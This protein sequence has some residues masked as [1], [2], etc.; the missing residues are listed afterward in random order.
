MFRR[1]LTWFWILL[2][3]LAC[4]LIARLVDIQALHAEEYRD[5]AAR[6]LTQPVRY[7]RAPRGSILDRNGRVLVSHEPS[8]D[9]SVHFAVLTG[10]SSEYLHALARELRRRG[11]YPES[12]SLDEIAG[13]LRL[14]I[15]ATW[16]RLSELTGR[17]VSE[18]IERGEEIRQ[19][20][21]RIRMAV[22]RRTGID[23]P[24]AEE[25]DPLLAM[26]PLIEDVD[27]ETALKV[28]L[29]LEAYPWLSVA[30]GSRRV[31]H[32]AD[33]AVHLL[34]R[35]GA[36]SRERQQEDPLAGDELRRLRAGESCGITGVER[37]AETTLRGTRGRIVE[38]L[39]GTPVER[40]E[41]VAGRDVE[42]TIDMELQE[43]VLAALRDAVEGTETTAGVPYASGASAVVLD[44]AT[45]EVLALVSY[46]PYGYERFDEDY[47]GL[48]RDARRTPLR[49]RAVSGLY[50]PGSTCKAITLV[51]ALSEGETT[52]EERIHCTGH[53]L[54]ELENQFRCW[55]YNDY[56]TTHDARQPEGQ[57][58]EDA[59]RNSCNIY[60]YKLGGRLGPERLC[61]WFSTFGLGRLQG[62]GLIEEAP[63][64]VPTER[65]L[66]ANQRRGFERSDP[67]NWSI[68]QGE[69][70][71]TPL[72][73]ANVG[74][75]IASGHWAPVRLLRDAPPAPA[76]QIVKLP[77]DA[78]RVLRTGMW[79]VV[80]ENGTGKAAK[81]KSD[82]YVLCGKTGSAQAVPTPVR[83]R[84]I[85][86]WPDRQ[87]ETREAYLEE[88]A[89]AS[90]GAE[91]P[92]CIGR[93]T[94]ARFPELEEGESIA[95]AWY[96]AYT[97]PASTPRGAA[98]Q[99]PVY[100]I[101]TVIEFGGSGGR[102]AG[103]VVKKIAEY[104]LEREQ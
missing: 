86:E 6:M 22:R 10:Q 73:I 12:M 39:D 96:M 55:I 52:P 90:F 20:V 60:F 75:T 77:P 103:P 41:P 91:R 87:R 5:L 45:R 23:Q 19:Q 32:D 47:D 61:N 7:L 95:H 102:V 104:L 21:A 42:L 78:L 101:S 14:Q 88:D 28:R 70:A 37:L 43:F 49:F 84:Y 97:Q 1:R 33:A 48:V 3:A 71:A 79:R 67:W 92:R 82:R 68:G 80:N 59:I 62:T 99:G 34:G 65:W 44:V 13:R 11:E 8:F 29:E 53:L 51:G 17:P 64:V 94:S 9:I 16:Q 38:E 24:V 66:R 2:T 31:A 74:A 63:G 27:H 35:L 57:R 56:R 93:R 83:Y 4:A 40:S 85:F 98:P 36:V 54:P 30:P 25:S 76:D 18:F 100:A 72:Q 46:P 69:V 58:G 50:P 15:A 89:A 81:L 26:H